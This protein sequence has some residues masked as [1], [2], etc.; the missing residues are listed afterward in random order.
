MRTWVIKNL[1]KFNLV[2]GSK[3]QTNIGRDE[4]E[5]GEAFINFLTVLSEEIAKAE[6]Q[7]SKI[8]KFSENDKLKN[9]KRANRIGNKD[10]FD[11]ESEEEP[12]V[13]CNT[14]CYLDEE[15]DLISG[16]RNEI[17]RQNEKFMKELKKKGEQLRKQKAESMMPKKQAE[18]APEKP[19]EEVE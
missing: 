14:L 18:K 16:Q 12:T 7:E 6:E 17:H 1:K 3:H 4:K 11:D 10:L 2:F 19:K 9:Q 5:T 15:M 8:D 13:G